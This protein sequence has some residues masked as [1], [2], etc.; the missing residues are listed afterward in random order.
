MERIIIKI[1]ESNQCAQAKLLYRASP[2]AE[3]R[4]RR[5]A[6]Q[7]GGHLFGGPSR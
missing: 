6:C 2:P 5:R 4:H 7:A 3:G 1:I